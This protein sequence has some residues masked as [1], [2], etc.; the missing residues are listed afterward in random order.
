LEDAFCNTRFSTMSV[1][2][3][4]Y[5]KKRKEKVEPS[6]IWPELFNIMRQMAVFQFSIDAIV[7]TFV[8]TNT[9]TSIDDIGLP[10]VIVEHPYGYH[11]AVPYSSVRYEYFF[12]NEPCIGN[13]YTHYKVN[14]TQ[15]GE[16]CPVIVIPPE[17]TLFK[18]CQVYLRLTNGCG[19]L[20]H[21]A[22]MA[23]ALKNVTLRDPDTSTFT[24]AK[25]YFGYS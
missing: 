17:F 6:T 10:I 2:A 13:K 4:E 15:G 19:F 14:A 9:N 25:D 12:L 22:I 16:V 21:K 24:K 5:W 18:K 1:S 8:F 20:A 23:G 3:L 7:A 11:A